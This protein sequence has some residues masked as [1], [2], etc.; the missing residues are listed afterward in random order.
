MV[1][2]EAARRTSDVP[3]GSLKYAIVL[4]PIL[5]IVLRVS[6]PVDLDNHQTK[7]LS[8]I[9]DILH[10][11]KLAYQRDANGILATKPPLYNWLAAGFC[12]IFDTR[13]PWALKLPA[14]LS[15]IGL[16]CVLYAFARK[17]FDPTIAFWTVVATVSAH[18]ISKLIWYIRVDMLMTLLLYLAIYLV[19]SAPMTRRRAALVGFV[20]ALSAYAKG[21]VAPLFFLLWL[22]LWA[23]DQGLL[24]RW[25]NGIPYVLIASGIVAVLV[26]PW[27][28]FIITMPQFVDKVIMTEIGSRFSGENLPDSP[29]W[30]YLPGLVGRILP[31]SLIAIA[32][33]IL[34]RHRPEWRRLR[35]LALWVLVYVAF[36]SL[37]PSR[38]GDRL[39]PVYPPIF[40]MGAVG[41]T[42]LLEPRCRRAFVSIIA[43]LGSIIV[44]A[45]VIV[46]LISKSVAMTPKIWVVLVAGA[47][48]GAAALWMLRNQRFAHAAVFL[49]AGLMTFDGLYANGVMRRRKLDDYFLLQTFAAAAQDRAGGD[50]IFIYEVD[51]WADLL[52]AYELSTHQRGA[53]PESFPPHSFEWVIT[54]I[55]NEPEF[56]QRTGWQLDPVPDPKLECKWGKYGL[57]QVVFG[58]PGDKQV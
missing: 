39:L 32:A 55:E 18:H 21:P 46:P 8:P 40:M 43:V 47:L 27:V 15:G 50:R 2:S 24:R 19:Y 49:I 1:Q 3:G 36:L 56:E 53:P 17:M 12:T 57:Y 28:A 48:F 30:A 23:W 42:Y 11:G 16:I 45:P 41:V 9:M 13:E 14:L 20:L 34:G 22:P 44:V 54:R 52:M 10:G 4:L 37:F 58:S 6:A 26:I 25:R 29:V 7:Q 38:R 35:F 33:L 5:F 51:H 31:W